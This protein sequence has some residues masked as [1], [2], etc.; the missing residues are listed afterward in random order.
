MGWVS[1]HPSPPAHPPP[2]LDATIVTN[3]LDSF[4]VCI[5]SSHLP[6]W[7]QIHSLPSSLFP[8][9]LATAF[10]KVW[11]IGGTKK[12]LESRKRDNQ[13]IWFSSPSLTFEHH[14]WHFCDSMV[15]ASTGQAITPALDRWPWLLSSVNFISCL[16]YISSDLQLTSL[17]PICSSSSF[18]TFKM[19]SPY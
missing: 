9:A 8:E 2:T 6:T 13:G 17:S 7:S 18:N 16:Y 1:P 5:V 4:L 12:W 11:C 15:S 10:W 19:T 3:L 14:S